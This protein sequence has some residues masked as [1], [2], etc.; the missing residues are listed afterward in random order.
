[1]TDG[2]CKAYES[3]ASLRTPV[4]THDNTEP[5]KVA[6]VQV[7]RP[8]QLPLLLSEDA[9]SNVKYDG[10]G[11]ALECHTKLQLCAH[12]LRWLDQSRFSEPTGLLT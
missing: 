1:M 4:Y 3:V 5:W 12:N 8:G 9:S 11:C 7:F 6:H 2:V 10:H